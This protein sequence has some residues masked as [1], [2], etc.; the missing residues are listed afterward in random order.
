MEVRFLS[1][2]PRAPGTAPLGTGESSDAVGGSPQACLVEQVQHGVPELVRGAVEVVGAGGGVEG[3]AHRDLVADDEHAPLGSE[4]QPPEG[5]RVATRGIVE[6][7]AAG[8]GVG[9][10]VVGLPGPV[11]GDWLSLQL[12]DIDVVE[13]RFR[14]ER[15]PATLESDLRRLPGPAEPG[16]DTEVER[17]LLNLH[18]ECA[19]LS[20]SLLGERHRDPRIAVHALGHVE[21]RLGVANEDEEAHLATLRRPAQH[22]CSN[23]RVEPR[24]EELGGDTVRVT[25]GVPAGEVH[26]AVEHA[27]SDLA[28]SVK[29]PGF[30]PGKVPTPVLVQ[31]L[32][33]ERIYSE[34]V[35]SH[36]SGWFWNAAARTR[37]RPVA[38]PE[39]SFE[40][41]TGDD[42][43]WQF[44]ATV[45]VQ[46]K[47]ELVDWVGLEVPKPSAEVPQELVDQE[48][49][50]LRQSVAEL[51]P[52]EIR[53]AREGDTLVV[54]LVSPNGDTQRDTVVELGAGRLVEEVEAALAG[55]S[56]G[57]TRQATYELADETSA[58]V[59]IQVKEI[60][61][62]L[63]PAVDDELARSASE[64][65]TLAELRADIEGRL[66]EQLEAEIDNAF[67]A[68]AVDTLVQASGVSPAGPLVESRTRELLTGFVRSLE[69]R[70]INAETYLQV[71]GRTAEQLTQAMA[72]EAAQ[73]VA[74]ELALEAAAE[75]LQIE[76]S[77]EEVENLVR[78]QAEDADED[79]D[80]LI[81]ELWQTG[82]HEDLREDLRLRAALDRIAA[83]VKP[84]PVQ[85]A[86]AREAIWTPD[87]EKPEGETKLWTPGSQ[88]SGTKETA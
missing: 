4:K 54:D 79:A 74:R 35:D 84:I 46:P 71:T 10:V 56:A 11:G 68:N 51:V 66:R 69:R 32:G 26:H 33:K 3:V 82:R 24:V 55:A 72:A 62:K 47:V 38:Q 60:K 52:A 37:I 78:E 1:P 61:E 63:L 15:D 59:E 39:Y 12:A 30:R 86:E 22:L 58:S 42:Q 36:I 20:A 85:L 6:A 19:R 76:V 17:Q 81:Q 23:G 18:P 29:I 28:S 14:L 5:V 87:K 53:P 64:F 67:R 88:P 31:R 25:V 2:A 9:T 27:T 16:V 44:S 73:S 49:E 21:L 7:L 48:L 40:L 77:D 43:D 8:E 13:E 57:E 83:E 70:G 50:A 41:P 65:D 34:A 75:R 80:E 45:A